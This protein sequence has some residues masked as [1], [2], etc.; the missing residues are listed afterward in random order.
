MTNIVRMER[1]SSGR[2]PSGFWG[3]I[4]PW[5]GIDPEWGWGHFDDFQWLPAT[6]GGLTLEEADDKASW[7]VIA[8]EEQGV[9]RCAI[10]GDDNEQ[11]NMGYGDATTAPLVMG[12]GTGQCWFEARVR[13]SSVTDD[14]LTMFLGLAEEGSVAADFL[15]DAGAD[16]ADKDVVGFTVW[17]DDGNSIDTIYQ[18]SGSAFGTVQAGAGVPVAATWIKLGMYFDG[19]DICTFYVDGVKCATTIDIDTTGF[20]DTEEMSPIFAVKVSS[21]AALNADID[22][23]AFAQEAAPAAD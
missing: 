11:G 18:T 3:S 5:Q 23:W 14:V 21:G 20:P 1:G 2:G 8:G 15:T 13:F 7:A 22:W 17:A 19:G 16:I 9:L 10:T 12:A 6:G 4:K